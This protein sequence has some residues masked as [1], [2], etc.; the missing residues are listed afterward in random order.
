[1]NEKL[2]VRYVK[3]DYN[4]WITKALS[5]TTLAGGWKFVGASY[6]HVSGEAKLWVDG[7]MVQSLNIGAG[8]ELATHVNV[9]MGARKVIWGYFKGRIAEMQV[10]KIALTEEQIR[11]IKSKTQVAGENASHPLNILRIF[12]APGA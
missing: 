5:H 1:M 8:H 10:Y 6:D 7:A 12:E 2:F 4:Y 3:R 11:A 9:S